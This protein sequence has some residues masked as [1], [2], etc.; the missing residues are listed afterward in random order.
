MDFPTSENAYPTIIVRFFE[1]GIKNMGVGHIE[2]IYNDETQVASSRFKHY[3][4]DGDIEFAVY[5]L[6]SL[7]RDLM[8]DALVQTIAMADL[9]A[10]TKEFIDR[11]YFPPDTIVNDWNYVNI[12]T[13]QIE[14]FG[15][16]QAPQPWLSED[17]LV[18]QTSYRVGIFGEFYSLPP[19][20]PAI[21]GPI[22]K[23]N[24][25]PYIGGLEPIP[26]GTDDPSPWV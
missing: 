24:L 21:S 22:R 1:R 16:T 5:A 23:V 14:G 13:D 19:L 18:Y 8:A 7:D 25:Y 26:T 11:I 17:Q 15:E 12:N 9:L 6:S 4:Y 3:L 20:A 10:Y 2:Y